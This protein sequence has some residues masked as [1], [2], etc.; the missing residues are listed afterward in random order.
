[1]SLAYSLPEI[2]WSSSNIRIQIVYCHHITENDRLTKRKN[3][4]YVL[5]HEIHIKLISFTTFLRFWVEKR[6]NFGMVKNQFWVKSIKIWAKKNK[7]GQKK[8]NLGSFATF[9]GQKKLI[10]SSIYNFGSKKFFLGREENIAYSYN[11]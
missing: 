5:Y 8:N 10:C 4:P 1:M 7:L 3:D 9:L 6:N 11:V 2:S